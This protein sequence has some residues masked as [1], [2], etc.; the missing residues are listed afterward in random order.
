MAPPR[1]RANAD[2]D[3]DSDDNYGSSYRGSKRG[4]AAESSGSQKRRLRREDSDS[5]VDLGSSAKQPATGESSSR[6][7]DDEDKERLVKDVV[8]LAI[9]T[10]HSDAPLKRD[11][12]REV[13]G[14]HSRLFDTIFGLAQQRLRD[15]FG[16]EMVELTVRSKASTVPGGPSSGGAATT[17]AGSSTAAGAA[18]AGGS[19]N[20][21]GGAG[22][23]GIKGPAGSKSYILRTILPQELMASSVIDQEA[24]LE[25]SGLLM[26]ILSLI[27]VRN[28]AIYES[29]LMSHLRRLSLLEDNS[30][31]G[32]VTKKLDQLIKKRYLERIK[33]AHM[34]ES[35]EK[36]EMEYRWGA[37]AYVEYPKHLV[38]DFIK[39]V[40][41]ENAPQGLTD[42]IRK[43]AGMEVASTANANNSK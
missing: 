41:G 39:D 2:D 32:D 19:S 12:I 38:V 3:D 34:D 20:N 15:I 30:Y 33:L 27:M 42:S 4:A 8:R 24:D 36:A 31:F 11:D 1:K 37:R 10:S 14:D 26:V 23:G 18:G 16:M 40:F 9:F 43:A 35:G 6:G 21:A 28:G 5:Y 13:L 29:A 17:A 7:L 25:S 22:A